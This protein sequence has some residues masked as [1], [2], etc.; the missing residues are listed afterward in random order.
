MCVCSFADRPRALSFIYVIR[1]GDETAHFK[2]AGSDT[3]ELHNNATIKRAST[4][5]TTDALINLPVSE[6]GVHVHGH[7]S[8]LNAVS[9]VSTLRDG[10]FFW[11]RRNLVF[12]CVCSPVVWGCWRWSA[13]LGFSARGRCLSSQK[14]CFAYRTLGPVLYRIFLN[15]TLPYASGFSDFGIYM[16]L[17]NPPFLCTPPPQ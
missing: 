2:H 14:G 16:L 12:C 10:M 9:H 7:W 5:P 3:L 6:G 13:L 4:T 1:A 8:S 17:V 11:S 15:P